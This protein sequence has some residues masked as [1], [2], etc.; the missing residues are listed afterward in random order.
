MSS[1]FKKLREQFNKRYA[2]GE[3][4]IYLDEETH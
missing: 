1:S 3:Q 2:A 4:N